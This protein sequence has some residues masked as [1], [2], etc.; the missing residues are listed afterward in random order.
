MEK[1]ICTGFFSNI[2]V[3]IRWN[4]WSFFNIFRNWWQPS[5]TYRRRNINRMRME[6]EIRNN[7]RLK[8]EPS[9]SN[10]IGPKSNRLHSGNHCSK[11]N[12][13]SQ[14]KNWNPA[15]RWLDGPRKSIRFQCLNQTSCET[16]RAQTTEEGGKKKQKW[17]GR[18]W[19]RKVEE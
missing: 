10:T 19:K 16:L 11:T 9:S 17:A 1:F 5:G 15:I 6:K 14:P 3:S 13:L 12:S 2:Y 7:L 18:H 4:N 8:C